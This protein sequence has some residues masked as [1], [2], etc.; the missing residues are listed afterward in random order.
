V[1][2]RSDVASKSGTQD[3]PRFRSPSGQE[4]ANGWP[5]ITPSAVFGLS[6]RAVTVDG[7]RALLPAPD[8]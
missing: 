6:L 5:L 2:P 8:G 4:S 7:Q 3:V 1:R